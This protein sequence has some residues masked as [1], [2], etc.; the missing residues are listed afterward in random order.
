MEKVPGTDAL[1]ARYAAFARAHGLGADEAPLQG[2]GSDGNTT[3]ALGVPTLDALGPR[4]R[5]FHTPNE[6]IEVDSLVPRAA[7]LIELLLV[8]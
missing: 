6:Y 8:A 1:L 7:A 2:G 5:H 3:S 4:G